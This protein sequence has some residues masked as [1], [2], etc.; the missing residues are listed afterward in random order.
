MPFFLSHFFKKNSSLQV[1]FHPR[2]KTQAELRA[3]I[4]VAWDALEPQFIRNAADSI[5]R[6]ARAIIQAHGGPLPRS[7]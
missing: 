7:F 5:Q 2:A 4:E 3:K 6:R 1:K